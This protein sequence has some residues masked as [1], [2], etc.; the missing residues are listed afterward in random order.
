MTMATTTT[1]RRVARLWT[2]D[3]FRARSLE[4]A[5]ARG[6]DMWA[7]HCVETTCDLATGQLVSLVVAVDSAHDEWTRYTVIYDVASDTARCAC[8]ATG[9]C[10]HGGKAIRYGRYA[11][12]SYSPA[13]RAES[14]REMHLAWINEPPSAR[15]TTATTATTAGQSIPLATTPT[16]RLPDDIYAGQRG[17]TP[18]V[19]EAW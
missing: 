16:P 4:L 1:T 3:A 19:R 9:P 5:D 14:A 13:G 8:P 6:G 11:A 12:E 2:A 17:A 7:V 15:L 18:I 10:H